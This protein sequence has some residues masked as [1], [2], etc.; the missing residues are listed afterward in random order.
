VASVTS[1]G[2]GR[3][4]VRVFIGRDPDG[5]RQRFHTRT[6]HGNKRDALQYA[7]E[8]EAQRDT[9]ALGAED[10]TIGGLLDDL[11]L[12]YKING[13]DFRWASLLVERQLRPA[14]GDLAI[15]KLT[16][17]HVQRFVKRRREQGKANATINNELALLRRALNLGAQATPPK[18]LRPPHIPKLKVDNVRKGFFEHEEFIRLRAELPEYLRPL[19]TFAYFTGCRRGEILSLQWR[20]VDL[21]GRV[22]RLE[23][24]T[25]KNKQA[26]QIPLVPELYEAL[27]IQKA[28]RDEKHPGCSWVFFKDGKR[29]GEFKKAWWGACKRAGLWDEAGGRPTRL[30]HDLR[31]TGVRNL[32][33]AGVPE[34]VAMRISGHKTR[35]VFDRYNIVSD[36][37]LKAAARKLDEY[38][39]D[40]QGHADSESCCTIVEQ[41]SPGRIQ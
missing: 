21:L 41:D 11:L 9:G 34:V 19:V 7:R 4:L 38:M 8:V 13:K 33:R 20:Q 40:R 30:F 5:G 12:D 24:G 10:R 15:S 14:F 26:R 36:D 32:I 22:V 18:V 35:S 6:I 37:D 31:R 25:T 29:I 17:R 16:T 3:W 23:P 1:R 2:K 28:I 39:K 27:A